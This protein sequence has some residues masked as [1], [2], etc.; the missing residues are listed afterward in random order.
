M[1]ESMF[2]RGARMIERVRA[3]SLT[4]SVVYRRAGFPDLT[5]NATSDASEIQTITEFQVGVVHRIRDFLIAAEDLVIGGSLVKPQAGDVIIE[6]IDD[7]QTD[8]TVT[9][10][11]DEPAWSF[12]DSMDLRI[13]IHTQR[14]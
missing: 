4:H 14:K 7:R 2:Q 6:T 12:D 1:P 8:W 10:F 5:I 13:R 9:R 3:A 11:A